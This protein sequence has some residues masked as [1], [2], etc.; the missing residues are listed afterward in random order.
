MT[1]RQ[2]G[3]PGKRKER[4]I[5]P[6]FY[7]FTEGEFFYIHNKTIYIFRKYMKQAIISYIII[8]V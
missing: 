4:K 2:N 7:C 8:N 5:R 3:G 6:E 1:Y